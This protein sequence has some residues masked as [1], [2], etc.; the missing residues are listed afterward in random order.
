MCK[1]HCWS[2]RMWYQLGQIFYTCTCTLIGTQV[3]RSWYPRNIIWLTLCILNNSTF[4]TRFLCH[5]IFFKGL[6][7]NLC[8]LSDTFTSKWKQSVSKSDFV[9]PI[10]F[11]IH[12]VR[13]M[14][15]EVQTMK[16][17]HNCIARMS[18]S[19]QLV[20]HHLH[21]SQ[22]H[23]VVGNQVEAWHVIT[24]LV[25]RKLKCSMGVIDM[26]LRMNLTYSKN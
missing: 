23:I 13:G 12:D 21:R 16:K 7:Q 5:G 10:E 26:N 20:R 11:G 22:K 4:T 8:D 24:S 2:S 17:R 9:T 14:S 18:R 3:E 6:N 15:S 19:Y 1:Y 25:S